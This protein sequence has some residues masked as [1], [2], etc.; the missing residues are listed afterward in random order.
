[1]KDKVSHPYKRTGKILFL[2]ILIFKLKKWDEEAKDWTEWQQVSHESNILSDSSWM[3]FWFVSVV[4]K[5][6]N[7]ATF[8]KDLL[9][10]S[11]SWFCPTFS[12]PTSLLPSIRTS[13]F[14]FMIRGPFAKS[15]DPPYYS[16]SELC[17]SAVRVSFSKYLP[18]QEIMHF[19]QRSTHFSKTFSRPLITS[20][21]LAP[22]LPFHGWKGPKIA[23]GRD[24]NYI[25]FV[26]EKVDRWDPSRT[27]VIQSRSRSYFNLNAAVRFI[28]ND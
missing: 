25:V 28:R 17:G 26:L 10:I 15:V 13:V 27:S 18:W 16:E 20:K 1:V 23:W 6:L 19:V 14:Y 12:R 11:L 5:Y 7:L 3:K 24:L 21:F 22:K 2:Y 8:S 4:P 9:V